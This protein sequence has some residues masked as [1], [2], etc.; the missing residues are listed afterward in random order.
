MEW[1]SLGINLLQG[2]ASYQAD[3]AK[4][5]AEQAYRAYKNA[6]ARI[7]DATTQNVITENQIATNQAYGDQA[8]GI[9]QQNILSTAQAEVSA[10]AAGVKGRSVNQV[11][12]DINRS[13]A[14][15]ER[16]RQNDMTNSNLSFA[17]Q[18]QQSAQAAA[19][20]QDY[21][22]IPTPKLG[23]YL[24]SAAMSSA[25]G[26]NGFGDR[27]TPSMSKTAAAQGAT[28]AN[29]STLDYLKRNIR[30]GADYLESQFRF[31]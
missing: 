13:A 24:L 6:M 19:N 31:G 9:K 22:Y 17:G 5:K 1:V 27:S 18:R 8:V 29:E 21:S 23:S 26:K 14:L 4:A 10:A 12:L 15:A 11:Q 3:K 25:G 30:S 7:S 2:F 28:T 16:Q 20:A